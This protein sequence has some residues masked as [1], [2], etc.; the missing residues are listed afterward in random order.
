MQLT[1]LSESRIL[2]TADVCRFISSNASRPSENTSPGKAIFWK[3]HNTYK[4]GCTPNSTT[5][6]QKHRI[7]SY[8]S[9]C[10][11]NPISWS[12]YTPLW[13]Q[14]IRIV[15][16]VLIIITNERRMLRIFCVWCVFL[17]VCAAITML[18]STWY[19]WS[20]IETLEWS[21]TRG[22]PHSQKSRDWG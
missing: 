4:R 1:S 20:S 5:G 3:C 10:D 7:Y 17:Y 15:G 9:G 6:T 8:I 2:M 16:G 22:V 14:L 11:D 21:W 19:L 18:L 13:V 12:L